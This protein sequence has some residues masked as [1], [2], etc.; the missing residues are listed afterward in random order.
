MNSIKQY[1]AGL[2]TI[3]L[4]SCTAIDKQETPAKQLISRLQNI[5]GKGILFAH[6]DDLAY[7]R[8]WWMQEG[9]SD[10]KSVAGDYPAII[11]WELGGIE[12][13]DERNLDS[14]AFTDMRNLAIKT[15]AMGA[16]NTFSWHPYSVVNGVN[17]WNT[18]TRVV[19]HIIP[20]GDYHTQFVTQLDKVAD[21]FASLKDS[22]GNAIPVILRPWHE[23]GGSW[24]WWGRN[25][26]TPEQ[27]K[28]LAQFTI[29]YL[30][31]TK[32]LNNLVICYSPDGGFASPEEF[33]TFYPGDD[34]VDILGMDDYQFGNDTTWANKAANKLRIIIQLAKSKNKLACFAETGLEYI[35]DSLWFTTKLAKALEPS[36]IQSDISYVL[37]WRNDPKKHYYFPFPSHPAAADAKAF[38][39]LPFMLT[40]KE[41]KQLETAH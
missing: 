38:L 19:E 18:E 40:L 14:V 10:V 4:A 26:C 15:H 24:F 11:G 32:K 20:G 17:S 13:G 30:R 2:L 34:K 1:A 3:V 28:T 27:Y 41:M 33:L 25:H 8:T 12:R 5:K 23:M 21:F 7:G 39:D 6:Q 9:A 16:I 31:E 29:D 35:P 37:T 36:D 22:A